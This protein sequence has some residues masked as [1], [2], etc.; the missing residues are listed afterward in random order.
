MELDDLIVA[1]LQGLDAGLSDD[2][3]YAA[4]VLEHARARLMGPLRY[5]GGGL[6]RERR[7]V[8]KGAAGW[9]W[10]RSVGAQARSG[11]VAVNAD[12]GWLHRVGDDACAVVP[13]CFEEFAR[14][15]GRRQDGAGPGARLRRCRSQRSPAGDGQPV[16]GGARGRVE[17]VRDAVPGGAAVG[18]AEP[19]AGL[20]TLTERRR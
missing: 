2:L 10:V 11:S 15:R 1:V 16:S 5:A 8:G 17:G 9:D 14:W 6:A 3:A 20:A 18:D 13:Y 12:G 7:A 4:K 19:E